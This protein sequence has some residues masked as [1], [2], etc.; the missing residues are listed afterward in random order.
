[1]GACRTPVA[2]RTAVVVAGPLTAAIPAAPSARPAHPER[3]RCPV[4][5]L[6][7]PLYVFDEVV[8]QPSARRA[9][10]W[11]HAQREAGAQALVIKIDT[12]GGDVEAGFGLIRAIESVGIPTYCVVDDRAYSMGFAI[13]Q[14]CTMRLAT[15]QAKL[16]SHAASLGLIGPAQEPRQ[17]GSLLDPDDERVVGVRAISRVMAEHCAA[18]MKVSLEEY[19]QR[20]ATD[21]W[22]NGGEGLRYGALDRVVVSVESVHRYVQAGLRLP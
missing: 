8:S 6:C 13:L 9:I 21:W 11:I 7:V 18:R 20:T 22:M 5:G 16:M 12:A 3:A 15:T 4:I 19:L 2:P 1:V 14:A 10:S 17:L